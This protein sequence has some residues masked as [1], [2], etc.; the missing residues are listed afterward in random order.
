MELGRWDMMRW[1]WG[2]G[3]E[4]YIVVYSTMLFIMRTRDWM[5]CLHT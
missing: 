4:I 5:P 2:V 3:K 1:S